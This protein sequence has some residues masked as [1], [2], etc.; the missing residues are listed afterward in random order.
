MNPY[1]PATPPDSWIPT[2]FVIDTLGNNSVRLSWQQD[3]LHID[4]YTVRRDISGEIREFIIPF[5]SLM[6]TDLTVI[7]STATDTCAEVTYSVMA[8]AGDNLSNAVGNDAPLYLPLTAPAFAGNDITVTD[9]A[10]SVTLSASEPQN[11]ERGEWTIISGEGGTFENTVLPNS[12]FYGQ[13]CEPYILRWT[14]Y[15]C[16]Q[17]SD[18]VSISFSNGL[19]VANAGPDQTFSDNTTQTNLSANTP[20]ILET[21]EWTIVSGTGGTIVDPTNPTTAFTGQSCTSYTLRWTI[22]GCGESAD[23]VTISLSEATTQP[24]AGVDISFTDNTTQTNISANAPSVG[25]IG[26]WSIVSGTGGVIASPNDP[27]TSFSGSSCE[28]YVLVWSI[29]GTCGVLSDQV[30]ISFQQE[31]TQANAGS[32]QSFADNTTQVTL[33]ANSPGIGETGQWSVSSGSGGA[34]TDAN[35]PNTLFTGQSCQS[36]ILR[37]TISG[38]SVSQDDVEVDFQQQTTSAIA[39]N[40][41]ATSVPEVTLGANTPGVDESGGWDILLGNGGAFNDA[42]NPNAIFTG[43]AGEEYTIIWSITGTC[44]V[45]SDTINVTMACN[46][47]TVETLTPTWVYAGVSGGNDVYELTTCINVIDEGSTPLSGFSPSGVYRC[48]SLPCGAQSG[49]T[50]PCVSPIVFAGTWYVQAYANNSCGEGLGQV[51]TVTIP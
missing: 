23:D 35:S 42:G 18:D 7:D 24:N 44:Y 15:G 5:D 22:T 45:N 13:P 9:T 16:A 32:D 8:R 12:K 26:Q 20:S 46:S 10:T 25:E 11:G 28:T 3:E 17:T 48:Q 30:T 43:I 29:T 51:M 49:F 6:F 33:S 4:G 41:I 1:D 39:G 21:G 37:W 40:D 50:P 31:T 47:P 19:T 34:F 14:V 36:Y 2:G 38:C 27:S